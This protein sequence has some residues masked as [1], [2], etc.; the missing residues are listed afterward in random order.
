MVGFDPGQTSA[1]SLST[2]L[3]STAASAL[4]SNAPIA[5]RRTAS[6]ATQS[7]PA[8]LH[9]GTHWP[10][11]SFGRDPTAPPRARLP[12]RNAT[13]LAK[14][15]ATLHRP[16]AIHPSSERIGHPNLIDLAA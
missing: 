3:G 12:T 13:R 1:C 7:F 14:F 5:S 9:G 16:P 4:A 6:E 8:A 11:A 15:H 10:P 2:P